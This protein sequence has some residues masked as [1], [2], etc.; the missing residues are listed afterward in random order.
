VWWWF[1]SNLDVLV[2]AVRVQRLQLL[3]LITVSL[4][5][6]S[7]TAMCW[8][9]I[10]CEVVMAERGGLLAAMILRARRIRHLQGTGVRSSFRRRD[11][12][13]A[14]RVASSFSIT[15]LVAMSSPPCGRGESHG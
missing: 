11:R 4:S 1:L 13:A 15:P 6:N 8:L 2:M 9:A 7:G 12:R 5:K 14:G 10:D 3:Q